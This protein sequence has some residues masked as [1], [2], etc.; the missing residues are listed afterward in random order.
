MAVIKLK[1][2]IYNLMV[3]GASLWCIDYSRPVFGQQLDPVFYPAPR[4]ANDKRVEYPVQ[5]LNLALSKVRTGYELRPSNV[6]ITQSRALKLLMAGETVDVVWTMTTIEREEQFL[7]VRIPIYK[8]LIGWRIFL[9]NRDDQSRFALVNTPEQ[10][11]KFM[12]GQGLD[13]PD[14]DI[15]R[16]NRLPVEGSSTYEA[17]FDMLQKRRFEYFPRSVIE[18]WQE[19]AVHSQQGFSVENHLLLHYPTALYYFVKKDN[20]QLAADIQTGLEA[21]IAD[22][23]FERLFV[24][25]HQTSIDRAK[26]SERKLFQLTNPDL[27]ADTPLEQSHLWFNIGAQH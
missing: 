11:A 23:S 19:L 3:V 27:P 4:S 12:A 1:H 18:I 14:K 10:L 24:K 21:A 6:N 8:G 22:G 20:V 25:F 2:L 17:L 9:I 15:L 26:M 16:F 7:P 13:W 5:L